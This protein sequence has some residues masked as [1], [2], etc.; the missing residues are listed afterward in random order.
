M[1]YSKIIKDFLK[2]EKGDEKPFASVIDTFD[3]I[4]QMLMTFDKAKS[5]KLPVTSEEVQFAI[6]SSMFAL[7]KFPYWQSQL[8][9]LRPILME[10]ML[11]E[12]VPATQYFFQ[13]AIPAALAFF[14]YRDPARYAQVYAA[15]EAKYRGV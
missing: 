1:H 15:I 4:G 3:A 5:Q 9:S 7:P 10:A 6:T 11:Q 14:Y 2:D 8:E 12:D 13:R